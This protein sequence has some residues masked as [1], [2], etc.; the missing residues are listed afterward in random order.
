M[1]TTCH[2]H[3]GVIRPETTSLLCR[4]HQAT[5]T[6]CHCYGQCCSMSWW[7]LQLTVPGARECELGSTDLQ[8]KHG[9]FRFEKRHARSRGKQLL[10]L[11]TSPEVAGTVVLFLQRQLKGGGPRYH[12]AGS[13]HS[14][15][16]D[17]CAR[18][19]CSSG[20]R[21]WKPQLSQYPRG[22]MRAGSSWVKT[23]A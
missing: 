13:T 22:R 16:S 2:C 6:V 3:V 23:E 14:S 20:L 7:D 19:P 11:R 21:A 15:D 9:S 5:E 10:I 8:F 17:Y 1:E 18:S 4:G 12:C